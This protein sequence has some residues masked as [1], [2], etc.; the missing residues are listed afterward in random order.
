MTPYPS[1]SNLYAPRSRVMLAALTILSPLWADYATR[2]PMRVSEMVRSQLTQK[3]RRSPAR[4]KQSCTHACNSQECPHGD[5][6]E[7]LSHG[8]LNQSHAICISFQ[9]TL[10]EQLSCLSAPTDTGHRCTFHPCGRRHRR[11][12]VL[13]I[14]CVFLCFFVS[15]FVS[16]FGA[17]LS[18]SH[19]T[20]SGYL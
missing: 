18:L 17:S 13:S 12:D 10:V 6:K 11:P 5:K 8:A 1:D 15:L 16:D 7:A 4:D 14:L 3:T 20:L 9:T 2:T 19:T